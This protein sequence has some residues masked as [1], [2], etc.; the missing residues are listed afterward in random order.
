MES[1]LKELEHLKNENT[2]LMAEILT[3]SIQLD[4][5]SVLPADVYELMQKQVQEYR[6]RLN[7]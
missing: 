1:E 2:K 6:R 4:N 3:M 7:L 5:N